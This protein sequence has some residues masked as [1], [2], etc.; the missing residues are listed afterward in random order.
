[1]NKKLKIL[2]GTEEKIYDIIQICKNEETG[3]EYVIYTDNI[4]NEVGEVL[5]M[6]AS[7]QKDPNNS[8]LKPVITQEEWDFI[9]GFLDQL[10]N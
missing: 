8:E 7:F 5:L 3:K 1:M 9:D 10:L 2:E 4:E 6:A